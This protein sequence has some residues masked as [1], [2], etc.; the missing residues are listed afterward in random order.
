[1]SKD[2]AVDMQL[3]DTA[4]DCWPSRIAPKTPPKPT[5]TPYPVQSINSDVGAT[6]LL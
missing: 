4:E 6:P 2:T 1:M 5:L 3:A